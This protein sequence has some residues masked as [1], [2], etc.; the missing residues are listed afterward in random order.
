M[1]EVAGYADAFRVVHPNVGVVPGHTWSPI[2]PS[3]EEPRDRIDFIFSRGAHAL[4]AYTVAGAAES[5]VP[6]TLRIDENRRVGLGANVLGHHLE[7]AW[8]TDHAAV[9]AR[10][11]WN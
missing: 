11:N 7:N 5:E 9:V 2:I 4:A 1:L 6:P 10:L 8:P 3:D